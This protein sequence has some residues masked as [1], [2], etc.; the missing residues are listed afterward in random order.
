MVRPC[1]MDKNKHCKEDLWCQIRRQ[2]KGRETPKR[3]GGETL[4]E[5][6][7]EKDRSKSCGAQS[8]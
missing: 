6:R 7:L 4:E 5:R 8:K 1:R 3:H 2:K